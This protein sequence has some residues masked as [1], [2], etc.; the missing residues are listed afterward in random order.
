[1]ATLRIPDT[2]ISL[3]GGHGL[4]PRCISAEHKLLLDNGKHAWSASWSFGRR[5]SSDAGHRA[6]TVTPLPHV[7]GKARRLRRINS[8]IHRQRFLTRY[9]GPLPIGYLVILRVS[10]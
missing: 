8:P 7:A 1:M 4:N 10:L 2:V 6:R 9:P 3:A 5:Q